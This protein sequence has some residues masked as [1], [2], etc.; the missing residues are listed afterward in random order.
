ME[1]LLAIEKLIKATRTY[2]N[3]N[4]QPPE[5]KSMAVLLAE[6]RI[7]KAMQTLEEKPETKVSSQ[8]WKPPIYYDDDDDDE[9]Y[10]IQLLEMGS[11]II[12]ELGTGATVLVLDHIV[13]LLQETDNPGTSMEEY[14]QFETERALRNGKVYNWET[15][16]YGMVNWCL[17]E[18]DIDI[19]RFFEPK[20]S[21]IVYNDALKLKPDPSFNQIFNHGIF[22]ENETSSPESIFKDRKSKAE[23]KTLRKRFSK[24]KKFNILNISEDLFSCDIPSTGNLGFDKRDDCYKIGMENFSKKDPIDAYGNETNEFRGIDNESTIKTFMVEV[25]TMKLHIGTTSRNRMK[26]ESCN[27]LKRK[28][29]EFDLSKNGYDWFKFDAPIGKG[30]DQ[31]CKRWLGKEDIKEELDDGKWSTYV[32]SEEWK[33]LEL[34]MILPSNASYECIGEYGLMINDE[35]LEYMFDYL[36]ATDGPSFMEVEMEEME[37]MKYKMA[38]TPC[39]RAKKPDKEFDD[40]A[41]DNGFVDTS[42]CED[43]N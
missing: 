1:M 14:V 34:E 39:D 40:W 3:N 21:A 26:N 31:F 5:E 18:V 2:L 9:E 35:D 10:S 11:W 33:R 37:G 25:F 12:A 16:K 43:V 13:M 4:D 8:Y 38:G 32:P 17:D 15:A 19:L 22:L 24:K 29:M 6:E 7:L 30:L 42:G 41:R 27:K 28:S 23:R 36:L 20:F